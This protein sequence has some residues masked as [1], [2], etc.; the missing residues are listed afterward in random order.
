M[1]FAIERQEDDFYKERQPDSNTIKRIYED[2][3]EIWF[4]IDRLKKSIR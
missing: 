4:A 3:D 2:F 1:W